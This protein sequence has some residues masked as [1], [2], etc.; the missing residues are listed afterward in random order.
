LTHDTEIPYH[1]DAACPT[2]LLFL[3][4]IFAGDADLIQ[5]V[6]RAFGYSLTGSVKEQ[7]LF[8]CHGLGSNGKGKLMNL[9]RK[10]LGS[11]AAPAPS[12]LLMTAKT[13]RHPTELA[14]L[15]GK[16]AVVA[17]E[18]NDGQRFNESLI[19]QLTGEDGISARRMR[20]DF[21]TFEPTHKLWLATNHKPVIKGTDY[22][23]WRRIRLIP[24]AVTFHD[25]GDGDPVKDPDMEEKLTAELPGIMAWAVRGCLDWQ[26]NGL[27]M[28]EAVKAATAGYQ[29]EMDVLASWIADCCVVTKRAEA[30]AADLY[31]SYVHWCEQSG[32]RP[33]TQ[34]QWGMRLK[35]REFIRQ[36]RMAGYFWL[37][38]GRLDTATNE[39]HEPHEP[40]SRINESFKNSPRVIPKIGSYGSYGSCPPA[41]RSSPPPSSSVDASLSPDAAATAKPYSPNLCRWDQ[42]GDRLLLKCNAPSP[43]ADGTGCANCGECKP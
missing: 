3:D 38:I 8:I 22:A 32:E 31:A 17:Q 25:P 43:N 29:A 16:R 42:W 24:F 13:E 28:P 39:P 12:S 34:R 1:P 27:G 14:I 4:G 15:F 35:E 33:E 23:I 5:F 10:L 19:K 36:R 6:Q 41:F 9:L 20:E 40:E 11:L 21:W 18:T 37:G 26:R 7:V 30:K 2:W